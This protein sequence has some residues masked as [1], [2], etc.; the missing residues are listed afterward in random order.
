[1][2]S[3]ALEAQRPEH[4]FA[5]DLIRAVAIFLVVMVHVCDG[6]LFHDF[7]DKWAIANLRASTART[8][9]PLFFILSGALMLTRSESLTHLLTQRVLREAMI[10]F[11]WSLIY[12][13]AGLREARSDP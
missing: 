9:V 7:S 11:V 4:S 12:G 13:G 2:H 10:T 1:V 3:P 5:F 8:G 6:R